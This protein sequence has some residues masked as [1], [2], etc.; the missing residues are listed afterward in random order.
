MKN[1]KELAQIYNTDKDTSHNYTKVYENFFSVFKNK[2]IQLFEIGISHGGSLEMW[3]DYFPNGIIYGLDIHPFNKDLGDRVKTFQG[4]Q[5]NPKDLEKILKTAKNFDIIIDD[6]SHLNKH[7]VRSF[8]LLFPHLN[9]GGYYIIEDIQ[10]SYMLRF[11]GDGFYLDNKKNAINFFKSLVDKINFREIENPFANFNNNI[12]AKNITEIHFYHNLVIIKK[13]E[14][15]EGSNLLKNFQ[16]PVSGKTLVSVRK[17]IKFLK[18][19]FYFIR[20]LF[21]KFLDF[22]KF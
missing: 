11:G 6:G 18:Y 19:S 17:I 20:S 16:S 12:Y 5:D 1:L 4:S 7:Q 13:E 8:E 3:R 21:Y 14:N 22:I 15:I 10:T 9:Y 2:N